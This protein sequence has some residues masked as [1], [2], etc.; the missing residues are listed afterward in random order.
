MMEER[1]LTDANVHGVNVKLRMLLHAIR[2]V[3]KEMKN[4]NYL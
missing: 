1:Q 2:K 4:E 3:V